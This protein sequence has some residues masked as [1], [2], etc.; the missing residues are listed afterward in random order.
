[1]AEAFVVVIYQM[2]NGGPHGFQNEVCLQGFTWDVGQD[3]LGTGAQDR[4]QVAGLFLQRNIGD[5]R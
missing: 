1:M 3:L 2:V 5:V 4:R